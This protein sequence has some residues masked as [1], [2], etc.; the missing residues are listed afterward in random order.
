MEYETTD[1]G[2][3]IQQFQT[4]RPFCIRLLIAYIRPIT[5]DLGHSL[6]C[7]FYHVYNFFFAL[8]IFIFDVSTVTTS[9]ALT[10]IFC[11]GLGLLWL[12]YE[13]IILLSR[14]DLAMAYYLVERDV[15]SMGKRRK[16]LKLSVYM[17]G[18][19]LCCDNNCCCCTDG[20]ISIITRR[21]K[22]LFYSGN[23]FCILIYHIFIRWI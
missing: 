4:E 6:C 22:H 16:L 11:I 3:N 9:L 21:A 20:C 17:M 23:M 5:L 19:P 15:K 2:D 18:L 8:G 7:I 12:S 10:T 13:C 1:K 14:L